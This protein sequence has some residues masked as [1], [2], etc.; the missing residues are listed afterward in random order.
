MLGFPEFGLLV[1]FF[2]GG[3]ISFAD[4]KMRNRRG[5]RK[6]FRPTTLTARRKRITPDE[7]IEYLICC[8]INYVFTLI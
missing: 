3:F 1:R 8:K 6:L 5:E 7:W 4:T 2:G